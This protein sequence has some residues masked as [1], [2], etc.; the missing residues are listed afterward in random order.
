MKTKKAF[1]FVSIL[2]AATALLFTQCRSSQE[3]AATPAG[4]TRVVVLCSG[5]DY[6]TTTEYFRSNAMAESSNMSMSRRMALSNAR[7][8]MASHIEVL[9]TGVVDNYYEQAGV[10]DRSQYAER[11]VGLF[12]EVVDQ[13]LAGT[14]VICEETTRTENGRYRTY[15]A[16]ELAGN[17]ILEAAD[18]LISNDERLRLDYNYERFRDTFDDEIRN[19]RD[20]RGY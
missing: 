8:E 4:E 3:T 9:V 13:R 11:Y 5:P 10:E 14:R 6:F 16:I 19:R 15:V 7:A 17:E 12:R 18:H 20:E 2:L 1:I